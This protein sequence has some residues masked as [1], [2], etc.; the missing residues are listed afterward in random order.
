[1]RNNVEN[2]AALTRMGRA[3]VNLVVAGVAGVVGAIVNLVVAGVVGVVGAIV[4]L[5]VA[6]VVGV[7]GVIGWVLFVLWSALT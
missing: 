4:I 2:E 7:V 3:I 5:V 1:M 6:G